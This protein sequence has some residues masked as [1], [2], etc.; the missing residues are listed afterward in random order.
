MRRC[1]I[2][3]LTAA[4]LA[5]L[6]AMPVSGLARSA[7]PQRAE[8]V[9]ARLAA[10]HQ[11]L[12]GLSRY[13]ILAADMRRVAGAERMEVRFDLF[14]RPARHRHYAVVQG[15]GL[16]S[17]YLSQRGKRRFRFRKRIENLSVDTYYRARVGFRWLAG[18]GHVLARSRR[19]T[20]TCHQ[21]DL[22]PNLVVDGVDVTPIAGQPGQARYTALVRNAGRR[23]A[24]PF[25]VSLSVAGAEQPLREIDGLVAGAQVPGARLT[26]RAPRCQ[27]GQDVVVTVDPGAQV[28]ESREGDDVRTVACP[29]L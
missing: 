11:S 18:D 29:A 12:E 16:G 26:F 10:C 1:L 27:P 25:G 8:P 23:A 24:G 15:P 17:W 20:R 14:A 28:D 3:I 4:G 5:V 7:V 13:L 19:T 6:L 22:R 2:V 9:S 21:R